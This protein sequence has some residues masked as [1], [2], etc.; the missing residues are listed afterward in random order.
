[1]TILFLIR[2][3]EAGG[4]ERQLVTAA[5]AL[6]QCG[7]RVAVAVFYGGG[8]LQS[9]LSE[10]G[11]PVHDLAKG[12]R[13]SLGFLVRLIRLI[14][15]SRPDVL[16]SYLVVSNLIAVLLKPLFPRL[17]VVWGI[18][19]SAVDFSRFG[20]LAALTFQAERRLSFLPDLIIYNSEAGRA[21]HQGL[22]YPAGRGVVI[23]NGIDTTAFTPCPE[24]GAAL[25][26]V[27]G[28]AA[29]TPLIGLAARID[30]LKGHDTFLRAAAL[31]RQNRPD[32]RF[33]CIGGGDESLAG[34]LRAQADRL[35]LKQA[36]IWVGHHGDMPAAYSALDVAC[37][38]SVT[39]GFPN[40]VAEA[41]ACG[42]PCAVTDV[43]EAAEVVGDTGRV[44]P[45]GDAEALAAAW[46]ALLAAPDRAAAA[47][48][49]R[50]RI[51]SLYNTAALAKRMAAALAPLVRP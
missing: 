26:Q 34:R 45:P 25:R 27:W 5:R 6:H 3:L 48:A 32:A 46:D 29:D 9:G 11:I 50:H 7:H 20:R 33:V 17:P 37:L 30:P 44:V 23:P 19:A 2:S 1:M 36:V 47:N 12:G 38:A 13:W 24:R 41:M 16:H 49:A 28:I 31:L 10:A 39:E 4:A 18:R 35:G 51:D 8:R 21:H 40:V 42:I 14:R 15:T 22:G 43:G